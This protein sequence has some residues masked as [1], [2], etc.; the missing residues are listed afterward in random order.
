MKIC[1][2]QTDN[3]TIKILFLIE[4]GDSLSG[5]WI[6]TLCS[7]RVEMHQ[8]GKTAALLYCVILVKYT[9]KRIQ[10]SCSL[11]FGF[12]GLLV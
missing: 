4:K 2:L 11:I 3:K 9:A 6:S 1:G 10:K 12:M 7:K 5:T 8:D